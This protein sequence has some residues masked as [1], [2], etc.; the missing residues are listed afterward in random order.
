MLDLPVEHIEADALFRDRVVMDPEAL[1]ELRQ[2]VAKSGLR[3]PI[4]V[5]K[6]EGDGDTYG[7]I[8]GYRR[9]MVVRELYTKTRDPKYARIKA[10]VRPVEASSDQFAAVVEENEVRANLTHYERGRFAALTV[11]KGVFPT[12][13][14]AVDMLYPFASKAKRSKIRSFAL[15][16]E[17]VGDLLSHAEAMTEKQ[18]LRLASALRAGAS[19]HLRKAL[20]DG[21]TDSFTEEWARLEPA[22]AL[23][24]AGAR[25]TTRG[26]RPAKRKQRLPDVELSWD[27]DKD[28]YLI[29][30]TGRGLTPDAVEGLVSERKRLMR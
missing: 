25:D 22:I 24:E 11:G 9:L 28:G 4:E 30:L 2:S 27:Q 23:T 19:E 26:G 7:L 12:V 21:A 6:I 17:E 5:Y 20:A 3:L 16:F 15:I 13:E 10:V 18:G 8:S 14:A 1:Q 29:R